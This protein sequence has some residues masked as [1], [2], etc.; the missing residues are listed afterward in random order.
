MIRI[1]RIITVTLFILFIIGVFAVTLL[2]KDTVFSEAENRNLQQKPAFSFAALT[3]GTFTSQFETYITDQF[4]LRDTWVALKT[5]SEIALQKKESKHIYFA[6]NG[7]LLEMMPDPVAAVLSANLSS[8]NKLAASHPDVRTYFMVVPTSIA[9]YKDYLPAFAP[10]ADQGRIL[11]DIRTRMNPEIRFADL[12]DY[13]ISNKDAG[14]FYKTDH[15]W[16]TGA[17]YLAYQRFAKLADF[18]PVPVSGFNIETVSKSFFGSYYSKSNYKRALPDSITVFNPKSGDQVE[19][20]TA[21]DG[22]ALDSLYNYSYLNAKTKYSIFLD[23]NHASIVIKTTVKNNR[24]I[25]ILKDSYAHCFVPFL[26]TH[27][28]EIHVLDFRYLNINLSDYMAKEGFT[29]LLI[30]YGI[31][32]ICEDVSLTKFVN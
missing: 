13:F 31:R 24:K 6:R 8:I 27:F 5:D 23:A 10:S 7:Y 30:L 21:D 11:A 1:T 29:D 32:G 2:K 19:S 16:T 14:L 28:E 3:D 18:E 26:T 9:V 12:L 17:A 22:I 4:F 25:L 20:I 15:H